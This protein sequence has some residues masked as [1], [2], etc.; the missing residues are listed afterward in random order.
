MYVAGGNL[1]WRNNDLSA[2][3][4]VNSN[5]S[6]SINWDSLSNTKLNENPQ[7]T[8]YESV[9]A[10][11][12]SKEPAN[13]LYYGSTFGRVYRLDNA[14]EGDPEPIEITDNL[15]PSG[16]VSSIVVDPED[17]MEAIVSF[18]NY[19]VLSLFHTT[20]GGE[21]WE[22]ISGNLEEQP[23]GSGN[24]PAVLWAEILKV[25]DERVYLAGTSAGLFTTAYVNGMNTIWKQQS[26]DLIGNSVIDMIDVRHQDGFVAVGTHGTGVYTTYIN[27]L[28]EKPGGVSLV[29]PENEVSNFRDEGLFKWTEYTDEPVSYRLQFSRDED[30]ENIEIEVSGISADSAIA[31]GF[32]QGYQTYYWRVQTVG[33][34]GPGEFSDVR[35][36]TTGIG[37]PELTYPQNES[38]EVPISPSFVWNEVEGAKQYHFELT[39]TGSFTRLEVD[40]ILTNNGFKMFDLQPFVTHTWRVAAIDDKGTGVFSEPFKFKVDRFNS[41]SNNIDE[42]IKLYPNPAK[43]IVNLGLK[44]IQPGLIQIELIDQTGKVVK[45]LMNEYNMDSMINIQF[46]TQ[47]LSSGSYFI[48]INNGNYSHSKVLLLTK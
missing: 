27:S 9:S 21:T 42:N 29:Y 10:L 22:A 35:S 15:F 28:P 37:V 48:K 43:S 46:N 13:V 47:N 7:G 33:N 40:T 6:I 12:L 2:I 23:N 8:R 25:G 41:V 4:F 45:S 11:A 44:D 30:F 31:T 5:D 26:T 1:V 20:N 39:K 24:G 14:N 36:F 32:E 16:Y 3:P 19:N 34:G 38:E 17:A 18:S